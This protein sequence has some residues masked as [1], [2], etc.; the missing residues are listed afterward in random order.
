MSKRWVTALPPHLHVRLLWCHTCVILSPYLLSSHWV[1]HHTLLSRRNLWSHFFVICSCSA[2]ATPPQPECT[3]QIFFVIAVTFAVVTQLY[4][5]VWMKWVL[6]HFLWKPGWCLD[7]LN[8]VLAD[9]SST[10]IF[11]VWWF[12]FRWCTAGRTTCSC[13]ATV[14]YQSEGRADKQGNRC[15]F[16]V[17]LHSSP[18]YIK[19]KQIL[20]M[21]TQSSCF[22]PQKLKRN[23]SFQLLETNSGQNP[24]QSYFC[25]IP[26]TQN[27]RGAGDSNEGCGLKSRVPIR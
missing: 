12:L 16:P 14:V 2:V 27:T 3:G 17:T 25:F 7:Q 9:F 20:T 22:C 10:P 19:G 21:K 8:T 18:L 5:I 15:C 1:A 13:D 11:C 26:H 23:S 24:L 4:F 6:T